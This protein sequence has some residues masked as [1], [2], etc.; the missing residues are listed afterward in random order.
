[1]ETF[2][3]PLLI[4]QA[5]WFIGYDGNIAKIDT[6]TGTRILIGTV[7]LCSN[8]PSS[9][10]SS[11]SLYSASFTDQI[12]SPPTQLYPGISSTPPPRKN[13]RN[14]YTKSTV[15]SLRTYSSVSNTGGLFIVS[16]NGCVTSIDDTTGKVLWTVPNTNLP[17]VTTPMTMVVNAAPVVDTGRNQG[18]WLYNQ[19]IICC[20][21]TLNGT[22]CNLWSSVCVPF[23]SSTTN[24]TFPLPVNVNTGLSVS[25]NTL[26]FHNGRLYCI[27]SDGTLY[28]IA[29][30][31]GTVYASSPGLISNGISY[32]TP[33]II[34][35]GWGNRN[36][37]L[38]TVSSSSKDSSA[39]IGAWEIGNNGQ[40]GDDDPTDDDGQG[41]TGYVWELHLPLDTGNILCPGI[42]VLSDNRLIVITTSGDV[43]VL[44]SASNAVEIDDPW[45]ESV[46]ITGVLI[47]SLSMVGGG[48]YIAHRQRMAAVSLEL[49]GNQ[50]QEELLL[51]KEGMDNE[52][53]NQDTKNNPVSVSTKSK[54]IQ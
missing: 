29:A 16:S 45:V 10:L 53:T 51:S 34:P 46:I 18:Y 13:S 21:S 17:F 30:D 35:N 7:Q 52:T 39:I 5:V 28:A 31:T 48:Y 2:V 9:S 14:L 54:S 37:G 32:T 36:H 22:Q 1:M 47:V 44:G 8:I 50:D 43:V 15:S 27:G 42:S 33:L 23:S 38:I 25:P 49:E 26:D 4:N 41:T 20:I 12:T 11:F 3:E 19:G 24:G 40:E 6:I